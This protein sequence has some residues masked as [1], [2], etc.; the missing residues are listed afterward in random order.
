[1]EHRIRRVILLALLILLCAFIT[2]SADITAN[3][4]KNPIKRTTPAIASILDV[5]VGEA[6]IEAIEKKFGNGAPCMGGH[7]HGG[8]AWYLNKQHI[9]VFA[10]GFDYDKTGER[11]ID[12]VRLGVAKADMDYDFSYE[13]PKSAIPKV[14][15]GSK[16]VGWLGHIL[17]GMSKQDV[18][19]LANGLPKSEAEGNNLTWSMRGTYTTYEL[20]KSAVWT[21]ELTFKKNIL[22][23]IDISIN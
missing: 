17:P 13:N 3:K 1:M 20:T 15:V 8:R 22:T 4:S 19:K 23:L 2:S 7:P 16:T 6:T 9:W 11:I 21:V 10:D 5:R 12:H 18:L 14:R